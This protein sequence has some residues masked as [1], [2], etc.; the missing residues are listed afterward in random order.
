MKLPTAVASLLALAIGSS[1]KFANASATTNHDRAFTSNTAARRLLVSSNKRNLR[2]KLFDD[3]HHRK[4]KDKTSPSFL[5]KIIQHTSNGRGNGVG[6]RIGNSSRSMQAIGW[7]LLGGE[8]NADEYYDRAGHAVAISA[9]GTRVAFGAYNN[10]G[11]KGHVK[12]FDYNRDADSWTQLGAAISGLSGDES[13]KSIS[14]SDAGDIL[15]VG[16]PNHSN[17]LGTTRVYKYDSD[18]DRWMPLG[19]DIDG[20][21]RG[22]KNGE[23]VSL[24]GDGQRLALGADEAG[25][26]LNGY[27]RVYEF[28]GGNWVQVGQ[29][30]NGLGTYYGTGS[31]VALNT[32]GSRMIVSSNIKP[33]SNMR[34]VGGVEVYR[35]DEATS[36]WVQ[37]GQS[38]QGTT[39]YELFGDGADINSAGD[40]IA[41]GVSNYDPE[42]VGKNAG[43][44]QVFQYNGIFDTWVQL[45]SNIYGVEAFDGFGMSVSMDASGNRVLAG[46][47]KADTPEL[48]NNGEARV[49]EYDETI[50]DWVQYGNTI[51]GECAIDQAGRAV[52]ISRDG[53][54]IVVGAPLNYYYS[55][56]IRIFEASPGHV[57]N[58]RPTC[59]TFVPQPTPAPVPTPSPSARPTI[60]IAVIK[61]FGEAKLESD[62]IAIC[63]KKDEIR[64]SLVAALAAAA[65][66]STQFYVLGDVE[67]NCPLATQRRL[68]IGELYYLAFTLQAMQSIPEK[69]L[70]ETEITMESILESSVPS[71][72][73]EINDETGAAATNLGITNIENPSASPTATPSL[74]PSSVPTVSPT[75]SPSATHSE[76][77]TSHPSESPSASPSKE[78]TTTPSASP[79]ASPSKAPSSSPTALP[80]NV[81]TL[82]PSSGPTVSLSQMPTSSPSLSPSA[83]LSEGPTSSPSSSPSPTI[84]PSLVLS[85]TPTYNP[86]PVGTNS[87]KITS[88]P[89]KSPTSKSKSLTSTIL[90][91][92]VV[93]G[94]LG[95]AVL[96][97][98][99]Y[100]CCCVSRGAA[101]PEETKDVGGSDIIEPTTAVP[102]AGAGTQQDLQD[103][104]DM[105]GDISISP[106][107]Y[108]D[109]NDMDG[110]SLATGMFTHA[111]SV[112]QDP[113][114]PYSLALS[115][116]PPA[117]KEDE[118]SLATGL[119][120]D[121]KSRDQDPPAS[122]LSDG[123]D[124]SLTIG[125]KSTSQDPPEE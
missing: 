82:S 93:G 46:S 101:E 37:M 13:G 34:L 3:Y 122:S 61:T 52:D 32:D 98:I 62:D 79:N 116:R 120:E 10:G 2:S 80:T 9:D 115:I 109:A 86:T 38:F 94:A 5:S 14:L 44:V 66:D 81:P 113:H 70:P 75:N 67:T 63:S 74:H 40:R 6:V 99:I 96:L 69:D 39:Y 88:A 102:G 112:S 114:D 18:L 119:F 104:V 27:V 117:D 65:D 45:G 72:I 35:Y 21:R 51:Y 97:Y 121:V 29:T 55:G 50:E 77:P 76:A 31:A 90:A 71:L 105:E 100:R 56:H 118:L 8:I 4:Q 25:K 73:E 20:V 85:S 19:V 1:S 7:K 59:F 107:A 91:I 84:S 12:V 92:I 108:T 22:D 57:S 87:R 110:L 124:N 125:P 103:F 68:Q 53:S 11:G 36:E 83:S 123:D 58:V 33:K 24:S 78:P 26:N 30:V 64:D 23:S 41:I 48:T 43:M 28:D 16:A 111:K 49:F 60:K 95:F 15:A 89:T 106:S 17:Y 54:H 47:G 42:S